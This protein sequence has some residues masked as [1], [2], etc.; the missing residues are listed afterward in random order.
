MQIEIVFLLIKNTRELLRHV[1]GDILDRGI[2]NQVQIELRT[3]FR[4][5]VTEQRTTLDI[6]RILVF[7]LV[8]AREVALQDFQ[9]VYRT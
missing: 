1:A 5:P 3:Q 7:R 2:G 4:Q 9:M 8:D 6:E